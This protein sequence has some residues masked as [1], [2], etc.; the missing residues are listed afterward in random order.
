MKSIGYY[1]AICIVAL[2]LVAARAQSAYSRGVNDGY[3]DAYPASGGV[4]SAS[5]DYGRGFRLGQDDADD[6]D[7]LQRQRL[8]QYDQPLNQMQSSDPWQ[9]HSTTRHSWDDS[10][11]Q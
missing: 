2:P 5:S 1:V 9:S 7:D 3:N 8:S 10:T 11:D 4:P 6:D